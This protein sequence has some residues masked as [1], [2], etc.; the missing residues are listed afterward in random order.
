MVEFGLEL[1]LTMPEDRRIPP[2]VLPKPQL[3]G[4]FRHEVGVSTTCEGERLTS[5][6]FIKASWSSPASDR[7]DLEGLYAH[8]LV[9]A[10]VLVSIMDSMAGQFATS[11]WSFTTLPLIKGRAK[12]T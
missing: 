2:D 4:G 10:D 7:D 6:V 5:V 3:L 8:W 11:V 9:H 1:T 12:L